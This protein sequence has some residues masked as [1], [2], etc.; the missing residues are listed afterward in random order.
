MAAPTPPPTPLR[1]MRKVVAASLIG[2]TIEWYDHPFI[3][4]SHLR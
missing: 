1:S 2:T 3:T 4:S